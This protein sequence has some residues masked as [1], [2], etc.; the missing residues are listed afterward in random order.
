MIAT[1]ADIKKVK[2][3]LAKVLHLIQN[4]E[5]NLVKLHGVKC[6]RSDLETIQ[7]Y[8]EAL[9]RGESLTRYIVMESV[10]PVLDKVGIDYKS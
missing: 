5:Y 3:L 7:F 1:A 9:L 4:N 2:T 6:S 8:C 10:K